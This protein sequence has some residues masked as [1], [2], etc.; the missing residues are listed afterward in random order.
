[1]MK[2]IEPGQ[3]ELE[4]I[5]QLLPAYQEKVLDN[6]IFE[7]LAQNHQNVYFCYEKKNVV[8]MDNHR[9]ALWHWVDKIDKNEEY[10]II[11]LDSHYDL[12][13]LKVHSTISREELESLSF[14]EYLNYKDHHEDEFLY[15]NWA[16]YIQPFLDH[17]QDNVKKLYLMVNETP[18]GVIAGGIDSI[19]QAV[20]I[21]G[22]DALS[23][24]RKMYDEYQNWIINFDIDFFFKYNMKLY[25]DDYIHA[26]L[27][28]VKKFS[29]LPNS[30][31][32]IALSPSCCG[33]WDNAISV[34]EKM[35]A[36]DII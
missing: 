33:G 36:M 19:N 31:L 5:S 9:C 18:H 27:E 11:H 22:Y 7:A 24:L 32:T 29:L 17:Y 25:S 6:K 26:I 14:H 2:F 35:K 15:F 1:M 16:N 30:I 21:E 34:L 13:G 28:E 20:D 3:K 4:R 23:S 10:N 8:V 12:D